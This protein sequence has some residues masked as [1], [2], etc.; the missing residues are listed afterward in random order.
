MNPYDV[1][2]Y[3]DLSYVATH[4]NR[5]ATMARFLGK[6]P[7]PVE[8][9]RVLEIGCAAG[10]NLLP[11]AYGLPRAEFVGIDYSARQI[12]EG[13]Q[14]IAA[15]G[16]NNVQLICADLVEIDASM[17]AALGTFDYF[18]AH[19]VYS[20]TPPQ[21]RDALL[22]L[23]KRVLRPHGV[24]YIS[25]NTYPGWHTLGL[26]RDAMMYHSRNAASPEEQAVQGREMAS[27]LAHHANDGIHKEIFRH[28]VELL[29]KDLKGT[30]NSFLLHDE[31]SEVNDPVYFYQF[32]DHI[33]QH[34]LQYLIEADLRT[35]LPLSFTAGT[36]SALQEMAK[37]AIDLEQKM[38]FLR[39]QM[40][41]QTLVCHT[42]VPVARRIQ[43][44]ALMGGWL[45][46]QAK[47]TTMD[48]TA[49]RPG[50]V[51]FSSK[52]EATLA[53]DHPLSVAAMEILAKAWPRALRYDDL[54]AEAR[55]VV[56][57][58]GGSGEL[59]GRQE[60]MAL[61]S[62]LLRACGQSPQLVEV[63]SF[64]PQ[65]V[66]T[67][68]AQPVASRMARFEAQ[69]RSIVTN[70]WHERVTLLPVQQ[71]LL[72]FLDGDHSLADVAALLGNSVTD[73]ELDEHLRWFAY[74]A[75]LVA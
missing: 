63:N 25:Y 64:H 57:I 40:F 58:R 13:K 26:V 39:N 38:D 35:V 7:A 32:V 5:L 47:R 14:R 45:R 73:A 4:P 46:S 2:P 23:C 71:S 70:L 24:A 42:E 60:E 59:D 65:L 72:R 19:G 17:E 55:Q 54:L 22:A 62:T 28:Y 15:L 51:Q 66:T 10:G 69:T 61:V 53:T 31:L 41:R 33:G 21:V 1:T 74:A 16:L 18:V 36:Q 6:Q 52:D 75:L 29:N 48:A 11:M 49:Q 56:G 67:V 37:D 50:V 27:F 8:A 9:C 30:D 34:G 44:H 12:E 68:S 3:I 43:P 20:W